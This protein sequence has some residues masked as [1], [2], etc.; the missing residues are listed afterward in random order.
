MIALETEPVR[1]ATFNGRVG[2][3]KRNEGICR[4]VGRA[5]VGAEEMGHSRGGE[6]VRGLAS[7]GEMSRMLPCV[8]AGTC[9]S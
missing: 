3:R 2:E 7:Y 4:W 5:G 1:F 9:H 6:K 8:Q